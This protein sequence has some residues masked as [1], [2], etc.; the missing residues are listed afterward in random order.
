MDRTLRIITKQLAMC[1]VV[2][3]PVSCPCLCLCLCLYR[4]HVKNS[5]SLISCTVLRSREVIPLFTFLGLQSCVCSC[6]ASDEAVRPYSSATILELAPGR[7]PLPFSLCTLG[8]ATTPPCT[9][10]ECVIVG[11]HGFK[12]GRSLPGEKTGLLGGTL[13]KVL[14]NGSSRFFSCA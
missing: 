10:C 4:H 11:G 9:K 12:G 1:C 6:S 13:L 3:V 8:V 14:C 2:S 7:L 5:S